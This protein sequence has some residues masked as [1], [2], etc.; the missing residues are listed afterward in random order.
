MQQTYL[1][2]VAVGDITSPQYSSLITNPASQPIISSGASYQFN[3]TWTD[4][5][6]VSTVILNFNG[7]NYTTSKIGN[8]YSEVFTNFGVGNY[9]YYWWANDTAGN[10]NTTGNLNYVI[11]KALPSLS[12]SLSPSSNVLYPIQTNC[13]GEWV[14]F[15]DNMYII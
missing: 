3:A 15:T 9:N 12:V 5:N 11:N 6:A 1:N 10:A 8:V 2:E 13:N 4:N 7:T 14:Q